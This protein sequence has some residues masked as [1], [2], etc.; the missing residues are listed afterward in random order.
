MNTKKAIKDVMEM[1]DSWRARYN[2]TSMGQGI[3]E[4]YRKEK[5]NY[6]EAYAK[7]AQGYLS[8]YK[9]TNEEGHLD[10]VNAGISWL[11][12]NKAPTYS[13]YSWGLPFKWKD[14]PS[15]EP[16]LITTS[17]VGLSLIDIYN[18]E[19]DNGLLKTIGSVRDWIFR[20]NSGESRDQKFFTYYSPHEENRYFIPNAA[21][22]ALAFLVN[23]PD[24]IKDDKTKERIN[25][26][27]EAIMVS[28]SPDGSWK[29]SS[30]SN[31]VDNLHTAYTIEGLCRYYNSTH[32][33]T[34]V[35]NLIK[36]T[37]FLWNSLY[38]ESGYGKMK[39]LHGIRDYRDVSWKKI[40]RNSLVRKANFLG[41]MHNR[42]PE[43][44]LWS[45]AAGIRTFVYASHFDE[46]YMEYA[47]KIFEYVHE[48]LFDEEGYFYYRKNDKNCYIRH[49]AHMFESL[50]LLLE[51]IEQS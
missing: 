30:R 24:S 45:Y 1:H 3:D 19:E 36:G 39:V 44:R 20:D 17:F 15:N 9:S 43:T 51:K 46:R 7:Y 28:Q 33:N 42:N 5:Q 50:G 6:P 34:I 27:K 22:I 48:N 10:K 31:E 37:D 12:N 18:N 11:I 38:D 2:Q 35:N 26:I 32:D 29:Y 49:Q 8:L 40:V 13:N 41:L 25:W 14:V 21:S 4:Y 23:L 47:L 16:Y